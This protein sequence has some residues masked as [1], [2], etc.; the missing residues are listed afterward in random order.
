M[1][2]GYRLNESLPS[3]VSLSELDQSGAG[4]RMVQQLADEYG[5]MVEYGAAA[6]TPG[7][8]AAATPGGA[9]SDLPELDRIRRRLAL[10]SEDQ[11]DIEGTVKC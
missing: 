3:V 6:A 2:S 11:E 10:A 9:A 5:E 4:Q 7:G 1:L 8:A